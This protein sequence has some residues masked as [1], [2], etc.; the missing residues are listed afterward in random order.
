MFFELHKLKLDI[1]S[2]KGLKVENQKGK[3]EVIF[4]KVYFGNRVDEKSSKALK[5]GVKFF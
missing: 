3:L 1:D 5:E 4:D 2:K